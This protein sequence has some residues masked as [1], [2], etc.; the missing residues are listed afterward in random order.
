MRYVLTGTRVP[1]LD[2]PALLPALY[3]HFVGPAALRAEFP[4]VFPDDRYPWT[5][6][7]VF[8]NEPTAGL[9]WHSPFLLALILIPWL[10]R[11]SPR[12]LSPPGRRNTLVLAALGL[13]SPLLTNLAFPAVAMRYQ[14]DF[15]TFLA[16]GP[17]PLD[18]GG[19]SVSER[20]AGGPS[21]GSHGDGVDLPHDDGAEPDR[22]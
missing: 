5:C 19:A 3:F 14:M 2:L 15:A 22:R 7:T 10:L 21:P 4:F 11:K 16:A 12:P 18:A 6:P 8:F 9:L 17:C 20:E 1:F 13:A